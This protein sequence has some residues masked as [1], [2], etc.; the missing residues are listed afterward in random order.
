MRLSSWNI[1]L[2]NL[3][4]RHDHR[5]SIGKKCESSFEPSQAFEE[6]LCS[7]RSRHNQLTD[8]KSWH[9]TVQ[10]Q[11]VSFVK[12]KRVMFLSYS[13]CAFVIFSTTI[14]CCYATP[15]VEDFS[16]T[17]FA[18]SP[19]ANL[20]HKTSFRKSLTSSPV[21]EAANLDGYLIYL[22]YED[23]ACTDIASALVEQLNYCMDIGYS[24]TSPRYQFITANASMAITTE[25]SD[26]A[27]TIPYAAFPFSSRSVTELSRDT[28]IVSDGSSESYK[29]Y[30]S[31][32]DAVVST[33]PLT[34]QR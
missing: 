4:W 19:I 12:Q 34:K 17:A 3:P 33:R 18:N 30:F 31:L 13:A 1:S 6:I 32:T 11:R 25:Y 15:R 21:L 8:V 24:V 27:C 26:S 5:K 29:D 14:P 23:N 9:Q 2:N 7:N 20:R 10:F 22:T 28:C 16:P